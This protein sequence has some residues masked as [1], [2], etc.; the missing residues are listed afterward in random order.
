MPPPGHVQAWLQ[1]AALGGDK[2]GGS[3]AHP[4]RTEL[5]PTQSPKPPKTGMQ[6]WVTD[7]GE[8]EDWA[9]T[10][11]EIETNL[12]APIHL[13]RLFLPMLRAAKGGAVVNVTSSLSFVP[14]V[15][16]A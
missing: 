8:P 10:A 7:L 11:S 14:R 5:N 12:A 13:A 2:T 6:R 3:G 15:G 1:A 9:A 16:T 4:C